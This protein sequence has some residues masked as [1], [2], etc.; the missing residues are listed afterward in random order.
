VSWNTQKITSEPVVSW[1]RDP[2]LTIRRVLTVDRVY[3]ADRRIF[4]A[5]PD[6]LTFDDYLIIEVHANWHVA[7][8]PGELA[9]ALADSGGKVVYAAV[10]GSVTV[11]QGEPE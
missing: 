6:A 7:C 11:Y 3:N 8:K 2:V 1:N 9:K 10:G 4:E 5:V